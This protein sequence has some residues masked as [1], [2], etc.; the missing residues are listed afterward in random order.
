MSA[1]AGALVLPAGAPRD[2]WLAARRDGITATDVVKIVGLSR[3]GN[4]LDCYLDKRLGEEDRDPSEAATWGLLLED[5]VARRWAVQRGCRIRRVGLMRN[6]VHPHHMASIDRM[7]VGE[8]APLEVKTRNVFADDFA[9]S[10]PERVAVQVQWQM[11]V[12]GADRAHVAALIGG[13]ELVTHTVARD[14]V[15]IDYLRSEA[16]RVWAAVQAG[17][18][19]DVPPWQQTAAA[20]DRLHP[21]RAG[22][23][24]VDPDAARPLVD[25]YLAACAAEST[26]QSDKDRAKVDLLALL[27]GAEEARIDG[28]TAWTYRG[29]P[30]TSIPADNVRALIEAHPDLAAEYAVTTTSRR[31][32]VARQRET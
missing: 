23:V 15:L 4:A 6:R 16:D 28:R 32:T 17:D 8:R 18:P 29:H 31:L 7:V 11:H 19:P 30:R 14:Q 9:D 12:S 22:V 1:Q 25:D 3:Y 24:D 27:G 13:Q 20:L 2:R 21:D 10:V 5:P 26:A